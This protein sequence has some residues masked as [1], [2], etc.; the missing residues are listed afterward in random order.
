M[1]E[2]PKPELTPGRHHIALVDP[3]T[4][5]GREQQPSQ[6]RREY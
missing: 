6:E 3:K 2:I 1:I 4:E 5:R